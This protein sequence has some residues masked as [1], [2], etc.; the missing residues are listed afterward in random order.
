[1][2]RMLLWA[3]IGVNIRHKEILLCIWIMTI[4]AP[5]TSTITTTAAT[6]AA[7]AKGKVLNRPIDRQ[8]ILAKAGAIV[9]MAEHRP[10][11]NGIENPETLEI[12]IFPGGDNSYDL[13][14]DGGEG[15]DYEKGVCV[16]T[17]MELTW[18]D[19]RALFTLKPRGD[20]SVLPKCRRYVL[21]FRGFGN[22]EE[23]VAGEGYEGRY[24]RHTHTLTLRM[25][26][27]AS[28]RELCVELKG[29]LLAD[30]RDLNE[31]VFA[32]L[33]QVQGSAVL[34]NDVMNCFG[35]ASGIDEIVSGLAGLEIPE[36][37]RN[38]LMEMTVR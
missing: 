36:S 4:W 37:W 30:N 14:E 22:V 8:G 3:I 20:M 29:N 27:K 28:D 32:F 24:D 16:H 5:P 38:V 31:R 17:H 9:P 10:G 7:D 15:F 33:D 19:H 11:D 25:E 13:F 35:N 34:K 26:E 18:S 2:T 21:H 6:T 12:Y 1:M 23:I